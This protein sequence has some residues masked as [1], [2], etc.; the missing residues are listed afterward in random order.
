M[1]RLAAPETLR[2][3]LARLHA[4]QNDFQRAVVLTVC[5]LL[6]KQSMQSGGKVSWPAAP[7]ALLQIDLPC[8]LAHWVGLAEQLCVRSKSR[9]AA[10]M[11]WGSSSSLN[12]S[13]ITHHRF[14][15]RPPRPSSWRRPSGG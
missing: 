3:D 11:R 6:L 4:A 12:H 8:M 14:K 7:L 10:A 5:L 2:L 1:G 15:C 13:Y 9:G